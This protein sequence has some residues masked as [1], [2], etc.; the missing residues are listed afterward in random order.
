MKV[1]SRSHR[2]A[3]PMTTMMARL[4]HS[5]RSTLRPRASSQPTCATVAT[6]A[7]AVASRIG[8]C[9]TETAAIPVAAPSRPGDQSMGRLW[10][11]LPAV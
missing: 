5:I 4:I 10:S 8:A 2:V 9:S 11:V 6:I 1:A 7:T 3:P